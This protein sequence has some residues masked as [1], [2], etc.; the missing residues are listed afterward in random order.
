MRSI[1]HCNFRSLAYFVAVAGL[2][3]AQT[4]SAQIVYSVGTQ[5]VYDTNIF[6]EDDQAPATLQL[7]KDG[8]PFEQ[9]DG[10]L[11]EDF[12]SNPYVSLAGRIPSEIKL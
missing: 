4:A 8:N 3:S 6:L 12:I 10:E 11:N 7:D 2:F 9:A 5:E 1:N